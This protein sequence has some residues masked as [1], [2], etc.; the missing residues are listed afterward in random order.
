MGAVRKTI[1]GSLLKDGFE[2]VEDNIDMI[3]D[4]LL[5]TGRM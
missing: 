3:L 5:K 2:D 4:H 1:R